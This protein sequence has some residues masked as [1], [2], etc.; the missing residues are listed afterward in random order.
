MSV[1]GTGRSGAVN[2]Q[3]RGSPRLPPV[4]ACAIEASAALPGKLLCEH[5]AT[6]GFGLGRLEGWAIAVGLLKDLH[7]QCANP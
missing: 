4:G 6:R 7:N 2:L 5:G 1:A 3:A